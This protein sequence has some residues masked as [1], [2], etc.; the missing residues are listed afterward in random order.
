MTENAGRAGF[1]RRFWSTAVDVAIILAPF[2]FLAVWLFVGTAGHVQMSGG[3][4]RVTQCEQV[5]ALPDHLS[6]P[7]P[8]G[9]NVATECWTKLFGAPTAH[10]LTVA[11]VTKSGDKTASFSYSVSRA[12]ALDAQGAPIDAFALD[13][14]VF[15]VLALYLVAMKS[16]RGQSLG[17]GLVR[18]KFVDIANPSRVG[19]P[20]W[21]VVLRYLAM[22]LGLLPAAVW[23]GFL[24]FEF[25][26][27]AAEHMSA[28][29]VLVLSGI[30]AAWALTNLVLIARKMDPVYDRIGGVSVRR[31]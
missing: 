21:K 9:W 11:R 20:V 14:V 29:Q 16:V 3:V 13:N 7:P 19:A 23:F 30:A 31:I 22:A 5:S 25:A 4:I 12:Y 6:P 15:A 17:D 24:V 26:P 2:Q 8:E 1:W 27:A 28:T 10:R 18:V